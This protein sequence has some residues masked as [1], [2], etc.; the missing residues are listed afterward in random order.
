MTE[1]LDQAPSPA[2]TDSDLGRVVHRV[3]ATSDEPLTLSKIRAHLPTAHRSVSAE[4]LRQCVERL[5]EANVFYRYDPYRSQ[6]PRYWDRAMREHIRMLIRKN[7]EEEPLAWAQL[8]RKLP[9]YA[10]DKALEVLDDLVAQ[11]L[12][13]KH[14]RAAARSGERYGVRPPDAREYLRR[15]LP[16]LFERLE[17]ELG[18]SQSQ[19]RGAA[20]ELLHEEEWASTPSVP[21]P[22]PTQHTPAPP[23]PAPTPA[24]A[25]PAPAEEAPPA[26]PARVEEP[27]A[28]PPEPEP[29]PEPVAAQPPAPAEAREQPAPAPHSATPPAEG[30]PPLPAPPSPPAAPATEDVS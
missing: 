17:R 10:Q 7:L 1:V 19:L 30:P 18:F 13:H 3:L 12:I 21:A 15:E 24:P 14:P 23:A 22:P 29:A 5:T 11:G 27:P 2:P 9:S 26:A 25:V 20:L 8:R 6:H 28:A 16:A 4:E